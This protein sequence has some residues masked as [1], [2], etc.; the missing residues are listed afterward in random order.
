M[1]VENLRKTFSLKYTKPLS[2]EQVKVLNRILK[3]VVKALQKACTDRS[4]Q[5]KFMFSKGIGFFRANLQRRGDR[6]A[7]GA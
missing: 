2:V 6:V 5:V 3:M 1:S 7:E 4:P